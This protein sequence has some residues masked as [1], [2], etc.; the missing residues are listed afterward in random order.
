M[1]DDDGAKPA[2]AA[3]AEVVAKELARAAPGV[4]RDV[5]LILQRQQ[6]GL[7]LDRSQAAGVKAIRNRS[8]AKRGTDPVEAIVSGGCEDQTNFR[9]M[10]I[11]ADI[12]RVVIMIEAIVVILKVQPSAEIRIGIVKSGIDEGDADA[13]P[14]V[15]LI[16]RSG[17][18]ARSRTK[19]PLRRKARIVERSHPQILT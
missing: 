9:A 7:L 19:L 5:H 2:Y 12:V 1:T 17:I 10:L 15:L 11:V 4:V 18:D 8:C 16:E 6:G 14:Y 3:A 13:R